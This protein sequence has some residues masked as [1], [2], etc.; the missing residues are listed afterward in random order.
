ML[1][2]RRAKDF[3]VILLLI[4]VIGIAASISPQAYQAD[5]NY[6]ASPKLKGRATGS[7]E[8]ETAASHIAAQFKSFGLKPAVGSDY[9]QPFSVT[10]NAHLGPANHFHIQQGSTKS[11][12]G[13]AKDYIPYTSFSS[14]GTF[15]GRNC[16][17]RIRHHR[18]RSALR[19]LR[20]PGR[21]RQNRNDP[22]R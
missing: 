17:C 12:L 21:Q 2:S 8:L 5:V 1:H 19:R 15:H 9:E 6:L 13:S 10:I 7:M 14:S 3:K 16:F 20:R 11:V 22:P 4:P 18:V